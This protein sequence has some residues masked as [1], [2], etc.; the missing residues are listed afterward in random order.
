MGR[1]RIK[2]SASEDRYLINFEKQKLIQLYS[3]AA[4]T[5]LINELRKKSDVRLNLDAIQ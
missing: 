3:N 5:A 4:Q 1:R 2:K